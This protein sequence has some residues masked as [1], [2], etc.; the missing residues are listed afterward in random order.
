MKKSLLP[1]LLFLNVAILFAQNET[2]QPVYKNEIGLNLTAFA[3]QFFSFNDNIANPGPY[4]FTY[5]F[6]KGRQAFRMGLGFQFR[7][8][9]SES[10]NVNVADLETNGIDFSLRLGLEKQTNVGQRWLFT[11]GGDFVVRYFD[12]KSNSP[13]NFGSIQLDENEWSVGIGP[14]LGIHFRMTPRISVGT[15]G[16]FY[17]QYFSGKSKT[18]FGGYGGNEDSTSGFNFNM[19]TPL[20]LYFGIRL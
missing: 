4:L 11:A 17:L 13:S 10:D 2:E 7:D 16:T 5:K 14:V 18:D 6:I 8:E 3:N 20:A 9:K 15:E 1:L 19:R 12:V